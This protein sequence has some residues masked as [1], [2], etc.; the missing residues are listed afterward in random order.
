[1]QP[2]DTGGQNS[3]QVS[4]KGSRS[5]SQA[6]GRPTS[7][8]SNKKQNDLTLLKNL[9]N[10]ADSFLGQY[11]TYKETEKEKVLKEQARVAKAVQKRPKELHAAN[12]RLSNRTH[13][14]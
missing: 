14:T 10:D 7:N 9:V 12:S 2:L 4:R 13:R 1:M 6:S 11:P 3:H 5:G 8:K